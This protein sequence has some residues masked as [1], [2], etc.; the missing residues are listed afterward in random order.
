MDD[1]DREAIKQYDEMKSKEQRLKK[2]LSDIGKKVK[3]LRLY[4]VEAGMIEKK[5]KKGNTKLIA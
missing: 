2:E 3:S 4:L 5:V 1:F